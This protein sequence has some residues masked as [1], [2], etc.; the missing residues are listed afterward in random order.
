[1]VRVYYH[2]YAIEGVES[3][4]DEQLQLIKTFFDFPYILNIG[5][6]IANQNIPIDTIL[7]KFHNLNNINYHIRD[8]RAM[9][10]EFVTLDLIEK[11]KEKFGNSDYILYFHTK[12]ASRMKQP[13]YP[14][15]ESWRKIMNYF[16]IEK[17]KNVFELFE[18]TQYN[19]YGILLCSIPSSRIYGG[20]FWWMKSEY[21]KSINL[22]NIEKSRNNAEWRYI[23]MGKN[24]TPYSAYTLDHINYYYTNFKREEYAK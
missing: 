13:A 12:G 16:N 20:N 21:A 3:I 22:K 7:E 1:M 11:D 17:C 23:Q 2:I 8:I 9:G 4:I 10:N 18:K 19:T 14:N 6:S 15:Y 5:I 24:W